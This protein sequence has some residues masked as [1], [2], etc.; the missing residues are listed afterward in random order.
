MV[1]EDLYLFRRKL[2][3]KMMFSQSSDNIDILE[4]ER[5]AFQDLLRENEAT[6][7]SGLTANQEFL[8]KESDKGGNVILWPRNLYMGE[9]KRQLENRQYYQVLPSDPTI[10]FNRK[11]DNLLISARSFGTITNQ[12]FEF[13]TVEHPVVPTFCMLPKVHKDLIRPPG[14]PIV[15]GIGSISEKACIF[16]DFF[17]QPLVC[18]LVSFFT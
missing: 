13:I 12:E 16:V 11:M 3:L 1:I 10:Y 7:V 14:R 8:I 2:A 9:A 18:D 6:D 17:L 4:S 5:Q 15:A